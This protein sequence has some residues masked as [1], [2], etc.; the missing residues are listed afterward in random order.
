[1]SDDIPER[2]PLTRKQ[3]GKLADKLVSW[4][5]PLRMLWERT[6]ATGLGKDSSILEESEALRITFAMREVEDVALRCVKHPLELLAKE[7]PE[8]LDDHPYTTVVRDFTESSYS[9]PMSRFLREA[10]DVDQLYLAVV[11]MENLGIDVSTLLERINKTRSN[12]LVW[13]CPR[14]EGHGSLGEPRWNQP[15]CKLCRGLGWVIA[16][17]DPLGAADDVEGDLSYQGRVALNEGN[18]WSLEQ[19]AE[20][21]GYEGLEAA[22]E[23]EWQIPIFFQPIQETDA[24]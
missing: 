19:E 15:N 18:S 5:G 24:A 22:L 9:H 11:L 10:T 17:K 6:G 13:W 4:R 23:D 21:C 8:N 3:F 7:A 2:G 12:E 1:M 14:C 16:E 20:A